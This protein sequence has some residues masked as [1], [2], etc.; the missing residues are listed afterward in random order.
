[1][2]QPILMFVAKGN[3]TLAWNKLYAPD[4]LVSVLS[5]GLYSAFCSVIYVFV[6]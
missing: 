1:M 3:G 2:R 5:C 6:A 4:P